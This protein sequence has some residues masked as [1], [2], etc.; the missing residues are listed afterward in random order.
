MST[1]HHSPQKAQECKL[2]YI[3]TVVTVASWGGLS[4]QLWLVGTGFSHVAWTFLLTPE[5]HWAGPCQNVIVALP[6]NCRSLPCCCV[7]IPNLQLCYIIV[8]VCAHCSIGAA[9]NASKGR[10]MA[11]QDKG[12]SL[13]PP[14]G[15]SFETESYA[16]QDGF[17]L[18][19]QP[20]MTLN[21]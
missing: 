16:T 18:P 10:L 13:P 14:H 19:L 15:Y 17:K 4:G 7:P 20:R 8:P 1:H 3:S 12:L 5:L 6:C 2:K 9:G 21:S 11:A